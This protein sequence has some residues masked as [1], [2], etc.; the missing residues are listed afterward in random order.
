MTDCGGSARRRQDELW[1]LPGQHVQG[2][3]SLTP[4]CTQFNQTAQ[5]AGKTAVRLPLPRFCSRFFFFFFRPR[6]FPAV[7]AEKL[8]A[9]ASDKEWKREE[10]NVW[11]LSMRSLE[12]E[13]W[14]KYV[15]RMGKVG[16][17]VWGCVNVKAA[18]KLQQDGDRRSFFFL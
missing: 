2:C 17:R 18:N 15:G 14:F 12:S 7:Q 13:M 1:M 9:F 8:L 5:R 6:S 11:P 16:T 3:S 4:S 10:E